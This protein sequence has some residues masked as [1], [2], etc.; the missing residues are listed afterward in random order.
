MKLPVTGLGLGATL[1]LV[2]CG[3]GG[4]N[5]PGPEDPALPLLV[6]GHASHAPVVDLG[7]ALHVGADVAPAAGR[8]PLVARHGEVRVS[9]GRVRDA[10]GAA[11]LI[12]YLQADAASYLVPDGD[13]GADAPLIPGGLVLRFGPAPPTVRVAEGTSPELLDETI[14]VVQT[15]NAALPDDWQLAFGREPAPLRVPVRL[16][17]PESPGS[18]SRRSSKSKVHEVPWKD[19]VHV[20]PWQSRSIRVSTPP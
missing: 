2:A 9:H 4:G 19:M 14:R 6:A 17:S 18:A 7:A 16:S 5:A 20:S 13:G 1:A 8:L 15:I 11:E 3:G 10:V 12:A